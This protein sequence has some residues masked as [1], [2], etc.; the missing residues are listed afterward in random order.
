MTLFSHTWYD[1]PNIHLCIIQDFITLTSALGFVI[2]KSV[3]LD[4]SD[5]PWARRAAC[6]AANWATLPRSLEAGVPEV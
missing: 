3:I 4:R 5:R 2:E 1:T 6:R